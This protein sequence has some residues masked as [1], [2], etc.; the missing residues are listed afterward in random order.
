[1]A[2]Q[3]TSVEVD[4]DYIRAVMAADIPQIRMRK[5]IAAEQK[6]ARENLEPYQVE[7]TDEDMNTP[8]VNAEM[9][10]L[11]TAPSTEPKSAPVVKRRKDE[12]SYEELFLTRRLSSER[13]Q[14]YISR[15]V[16]E[17]INSYLTVISSGI[18]LTSYLD[19]I[20]RQHLEQYKENI[21]Q[22]YEQKSKK[23]L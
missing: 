4:E 13:S 7:V 8:Q 18:T 22:L 11:L 20:I 9:K 10:E 1:M 19:S 17:T 23:P 2:K 6:A 12:R 21:N 5:Q 15:E 14:C 3:R 16:F